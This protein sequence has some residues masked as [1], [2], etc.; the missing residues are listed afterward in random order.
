MYKGPKGVH[1]VGMGV[2]DYAGMRE[3]Y[4]NTLEMTKSYAEMPDSWN[5]MVDMFRTSYHRFSCILFSQDA[6][7]V[8]VELVSVSIPLPK[9]I[10]RDGVYGDVGV[11]KMT[12]A[13]SDVRSVY[14]EK[15][16][17]INFASKPK[18]ARLTG[19]GDYNFVY[20]RDPE[21]NLIEFVSGPK[22]EVKDQFGG[23][24][25]LGVGV[26]DLERSMEFY[27]KFVGFDTIVVKPHERF[28]GMV[29]EVSGAS[30]TQVRS[31]LLANSKGG[32]MLEVYECMK[33]R[34]RSIPLNTYWG[35]FGYLE[36]CVEADDIHEMVNYCK[37]QGLEFLHAPTMGFE[38]E[39][40]EL[41]FM[42]IK[43]PD[44]IPVE[45]MGWVPMAKKRSPGTIKAVEFFGGKEEFLGH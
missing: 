1:H 18:S 26:T 3:F 11:N 12:I 16:G 31:C 28:S 17:K 27:Q 37:K 24:R 8:F 34:G 13:V 30:V 21:G 38:A 41:W 23:V 22:L 2:R 39:D 29:D 35:D 25:W 9:P 14:K 7:G 42:Y 45:T 20:A 19:W 44:G 6:G 43:D 40:M 5:S 32:G 10:R 33:P 15:K 4:V 36:L